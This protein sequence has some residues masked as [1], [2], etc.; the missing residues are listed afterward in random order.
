MS[1][2]SAIDLHANNHVLTIID[3]QDKRVFEQRLDNGL[4]QTL[5]ALEPFRSALTAIAIESTVSVQPPHLPR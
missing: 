1:F 4:E 5:K 2:Y 3:D